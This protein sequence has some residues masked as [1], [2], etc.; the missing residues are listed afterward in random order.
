MHFHLSQLFSLIRPG[1]STARTTTQSLPPCCTVSSSLLSSTTPVHLLGQYRDPRHRVICDH[2]TV[3]SF[4]PYMN[5]WM[6]CS[7][8]YLYILKKMQTFGRSIGPPTQTPGPPTSQSPPPKTGR[9]ERR[10]ATT[11][12][13]NEFDSIR[14]ILSWCCCC[15]GR[16]YIVIYAHTSC[17]ILDPTHSTNTR[18]PRDPETEKPSA[19]TAPDLD[20]IMTG[21]RSHMCLNQLI[22][23]AARPQQRSC[24]TTYRTS[25][26]CRL[27]RSLPFSLEAAKTKK[28]RPLSVP[29]LSKS[30]IHSLHSLDSIH[31]H[32]P[33]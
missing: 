1:T 26:P 27:F 15:S 9:K 29:S 4:G 11:A 14:F 8:Y 33:S 19:E 21:P 23:G 5:S 30:L 32:H 31:I 10:E 7:A 2:T 12:C 3:F 6:P 18:G 16:L 28:S 20:V 22:A 17:W 24:R 25:H 13:C